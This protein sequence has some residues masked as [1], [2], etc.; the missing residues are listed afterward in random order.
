[1]EAGIMKTELYTIAR[2]SATAVLTRMLTRAAIGLSLMVAVLAKLGYG[3]VCD[4]TNSLTLP[5]FCTQEPFI[6]GD[7][8]RDSSVDIGD[9]I[10]A[11]EVL[12]FGG[13]EV[14]P[15]FCEDAADAND[16][17]HLDVSD[18]IYT[19]WY[20]FGGG[21]PPPPPFPDPGRDPTEDGLRCPPE[22]IIGDDHPVERQP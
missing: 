15:L 5:D 2:T 8:N 9:P 17:G 11:L 20:L 18:P 21:S 13:E 19:L 7:A 6:R 10:A 12:Y 1:M 4:T 3:G 22:P 16:D 14:V